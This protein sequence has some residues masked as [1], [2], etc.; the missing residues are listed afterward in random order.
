MSTIKVLGIDSG[1]SCFHLIGSDQRFPQESQS[2]K[3]G[4]TDLSTS[5]LSY[6]F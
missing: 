4:R 1:K 5:F 6:R 2:P 3:I